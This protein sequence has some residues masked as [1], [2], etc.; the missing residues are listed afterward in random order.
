MKKLLLSI[1]VIVLLTGCAVKPQRIV[2]T[3]EK[4][5]YVPLPE[6]Y[7]TPCKTTKPINKQ[8]YDS[9]NDSSE[10]ETLLANNIISL[11]KDIYTCNKQIDSIK[12]FNDEQIQ[13]VEKHNNKKKK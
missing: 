6:E 11:H 9:I 1:F 10:K 12:E 7:L 5:V 13:L 8:E 3:Q 2:V 4:L